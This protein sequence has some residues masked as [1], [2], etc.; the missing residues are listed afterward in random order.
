MREAVERISGRRVR[1]FLS[2]ISPD[3]LAGEIFVLADDR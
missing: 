3:G 2:Q 1:S